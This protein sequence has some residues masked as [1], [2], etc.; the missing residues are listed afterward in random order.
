[1]C[2]YYTPLTFEKHLNLTDTTSTNNK[3]LQPDIQW[4][5]VGIALGAHISWGLYP[6]LARYLQTVSNLPTFSILAL[7]NW[8]VL[9]VIG[10]FLWNHTNRQ[11]FRQPL[12]WLFGLIVIIRAVTNI[13]SARF[14]LAIYVQLITQLTPFIV[15]LISTLAFREKLPR[16]TIPAISLALLGSIMMIGTDFGGS[17]MIDPNRQDW[18]GIGLAFISVTTLS[19]YMVL[20]RRAANH[21]ISGEA[22]L[23]I[24]LIGISTVSAI[25]SAII[26]EN[27]TIYIQMGINGWAVFLAFTFLV[28]LGANLGQIHAIRHIGA[29]F[30]SSMLASR[31]VVSIVFGALLL[32]EQ[33]SSAWQIIGAAIVLVTITWYLWQQ[34]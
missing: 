33:L 16:F 30:V 18:L 19:I 25:T 11:V 22:L 5:W 31:L 2:D 24:Q 26:G 15:I 9:T 12:F 34:R 32:G 4:G 3:A 28:F 17:T 20:I 8:I 7:G 13:L 1:M 14:T 10:K 21:H 6:V 27:W 29:P 23:L